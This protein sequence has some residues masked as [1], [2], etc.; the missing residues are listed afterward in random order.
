M[1]VPLSRAV[2]MLTLLW[3]FQGLAEPPEKQ[4]F[5]ET[6]ARAEKGEAEAQLHLGNLYLTGSGVSKS[7][8][9]AAKWHRKAAE[10]GLAVAQYQLGI[11]CAFGEGV[12]MDK[13]EAA[14]WFQKAAE[15]HLVDAQLEVAR[16]YLHGEGV[17]VNGEEAVYWFRK[18]AAQGSADA[19][20]ELGKCYMEG[21]GASRDIELG[22]KWIRHAAERGLP[23]AQN[24]LGQCYQKG[25]GVTRDALQAYKWFALAAA[26]DDARAA[27][28]RV[29][30]AKVET[31]LTKEQVAEA[32][33][34]AREFKP[35]N[36]P[37]PEDIAI[38]QETSGTS[39]T[40]VTGNAGTGIVNVE[41]RD[42]RSEV[43]A[44]GAFVG[45]SPAKLRLK[46]GPHLIEVKRAG[47]KDYRREVTVTAGSD[48]SLRVEL[49]KP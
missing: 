4:L 31:Q 44:D 15:Q 37:L 9:K 13:A 28:I 45:N 6:Q 7:P 27:D 14:L 25:T 48:L 21:T 34:L 20:Y 47:F 22:V 2:L 46:E 11:D 36:S 24:T 41:S 43:F 10:Q 39:S 30:I 17:D 35:A 1:A 18:A 38:T 40:T 8:G 3:A 16:C 19:E 49:E 33:R 32:Q 42:P 5:K 12:K 29:S 23:P 26:R